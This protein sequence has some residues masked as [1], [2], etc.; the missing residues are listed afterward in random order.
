MKKPSSF[1]LKDGTLGTI[2]YTETGVLI[3][4]ADGTNVSI[5]STSL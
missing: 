2:T 4:T 3:H 1:R 5:G